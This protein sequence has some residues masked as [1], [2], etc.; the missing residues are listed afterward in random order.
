MFPVR[1]LHLNDVVDLQ[2]IMVGGAD[3]LVAKLTVMREKVGSP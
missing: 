2:I 1:I 3:V